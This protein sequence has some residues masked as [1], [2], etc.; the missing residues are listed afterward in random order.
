MFTKYCKRPLTG[1]FLI[2]QLEVKRFFDTPRETVGFLGINGTVELFTLEDEYREDK[3]LHETRIPS[4]RYK[5]ILKKYGGFHN[6]Y[7]TRFGSEHKG[8]LQ[9]Q[10]VPGFTDILIHAGNTE[11]DTSG[12]L[13]V[14]FGATCDRRGATYISDSARAYLFL[15]KKV[16]QAMEN[17]EDVFITIYDRE[18]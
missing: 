1:V 6:R 5:I 12:C 2:M 14:G 9:L 18:Q 13:L 11:A 4:G 10:D 15:Y 16:I 3:V 7:S 17:G 8:M